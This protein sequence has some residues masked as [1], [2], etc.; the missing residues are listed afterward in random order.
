MST[1]MHKSWGLLA[2]LAGAFFLTGC[3]IGEVLQIENTTTCHKVINLTGREPG[4]GRLEFDLAVPESVL[5]SVTLGEITSSQAKQILGGLVKTYGGNAIRKFDWCQLDPPS[6]KS[7][8]VITRG[9]IVPN[10][11]WVADFTPS[12]PSG[13]RPNNLHLAGMRFTVDNGADSIRA[14]AV[15]KEKVM[16]GHELNVELPIAKLTIYKYQ[17]RA[18][19]DFAR[20]DHF[21][22]HTA[23]IGETPDDN[24]KILQIRSFD[25]SYDTLLRRTK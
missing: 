5:A 13:P 18:A 16:A 3:P 22:I 24:V 25:R 12:H 19:F 8:L 6:V 20:N 15:S 2:A 7:N 11:E 14:F 10:S 23:I 17:S 4:L 9:E 21:E 1:T